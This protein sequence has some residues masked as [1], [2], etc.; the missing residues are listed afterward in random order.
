MAGN[1]LSCFKFIPLELSRKNF[2]FKLTATSLAISQNF[3]HTEGKRH[4]P[5]T[6]HI[7]FD[8]SRPADWNKPLADRIRLLVVK[9][10][11]FHRWN[12]NW[13]DPSDCHRYATASSH[14]RFDSYCLSDSN[15]TLADWIR[16]LAV[17]LPQLLLSSPGEVATELTLVTA[18]DMP[19]LRTIY[20]S[21][22]LVRQILMGSLRTESDRWLWSD[23]IF[24]VGSPDGVA[25]DY[26]LTTAIG[27]P[28]LRPIYHLIRLVRRIQM[29][30]FST[31][32]D[33]W[34]ACYP[35]FSSTESYRHAPALS[36]IPFDSSCPPDSNATLADWIWL[37]AVKL[38]YLLVGYPGGVATDS[39]LATA[40]VMPELRAI[41]HSNRLVHW[42]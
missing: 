26:S 2:T 31:L 38:P 27:M 17:K 28:Q 21:I 41:Y 25:T 10:P 32:A 22:R 6:S 42:I 35:S 15:K 19:Q 30:C 12:S 34:L 23:L 37:L 18:T 20:H 4:A 36:N 33:A 3:T 7:P 8:S 13:A 9:W 39:C 16:P 14:I 40:T 24:L 5:T 29:R 11:E 1:L